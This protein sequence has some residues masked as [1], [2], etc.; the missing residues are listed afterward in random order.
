VDIQ[1]RVQADMLNRHKPEGIS[2]MVDWPEGASG[3][4]R[5]DGKVGVAAKLVAAHEYPSVKLTGVIL[6]IGIDDL[7]EGLHE[8]VLEVA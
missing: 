2:V 3:L 6:Y 7:G 8:V 5:T 4:V 1:D